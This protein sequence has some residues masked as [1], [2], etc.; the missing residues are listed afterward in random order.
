MILECPTCQTKFRINPELLGSSG[1]KVKC[2]SCSNIWMAVPDGMPDAPAIVPE[3]VVASDPPPETVGMFSKEQVGQIVGQSVLDD[4]ANET[5]RGPELGD[6]VPKIESEID[7]NAKKA[8]PTSSKNNEPEIVSSTSMIVWLVVATLCVS[9]FI[10]LILARS[11]VVK[12]WEPMAKFYET[13]GLSV[14]VLGEGLRFEN[15]QQSLESSTNDESQLIISGDI[16]NISNEQLHVPNIRIKPKDESN[17]ILKEA[18]VDV[19]IKDL[20]PGEMTR[21]RVVLPSNTPT[22][23]DDRLV[24]YEE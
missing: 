23:K 4:V 24:F 7:L 12:I 13:V 11:Q 16:V 14:P 17:I 3:P 15:I 8:A 22:S 20:L 1:R 21:F 6:A 9:I 10:G 19:N 18:K 2:K 5:E